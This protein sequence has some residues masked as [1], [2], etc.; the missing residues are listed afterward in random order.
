[1]R[2][3]LW[4]QHRRQIPPKRLP[5]PPWQDGYHSIVLR[6]ETP[7]YR[8][9]ATCDHL[10]VEPPTEPQSTAPSATGTKGATHP[11]MT[12]RTVERDQS[13][14]TC[15]HLAVTEDRLTT[16]GTSHQD[17]ETAD[18]HRNQFSSWAKVGEDTLD[19]TAWRHFV[20]K[21]F[22]YARAR[23]LCACTIRAW[24]WTVYCV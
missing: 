2:K 1:M 3:V 11:T 6:L 14:T 8:P 13:R 10:A 23:W 5:I 17:K 18:I 7:Q 24:I 22:I 16:D 9:L 15:D 4:K 19:E 21:L 20:R 12:Q